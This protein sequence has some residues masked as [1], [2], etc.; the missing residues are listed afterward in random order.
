MRSEKEI[1]DDIKNFTPTDGNWLPLDE[2]FFELWKHPASLEW[3]EPLLE[4]FEMFPD[5][6]GAGVLW[7]IIHGIEEIDGYEPILEKSNKNNPCEM[8]EIMLNRIE[9]A[10]KA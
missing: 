1:F 2:L 3:V 6:D 7:T 9:N 5:E 8:K 10:K 4:V